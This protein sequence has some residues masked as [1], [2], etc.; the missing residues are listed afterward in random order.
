MVI[1]DGQ[2]S[3]ALQS[4][5]VVLLAS[6]TA[7]LEAML[8]K[9]PMVVAYRVKPL[10]YI[11]AKALVK[12]KYTSLPN[13]IADKEIVKELS[14]A[15][16][17]VENIVAELTHLINQDNSKLIDTFTSLHQLIKCDAD[18]QA[19]QAVVNLLNKKNKHE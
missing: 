4:A 17:T 2:A 10:T 9:T 16:C 8:A 6:G 15:N 5:D 7:A 13:L 19:A 18:V 14:Q 11:I 12:V 1:F 3:A